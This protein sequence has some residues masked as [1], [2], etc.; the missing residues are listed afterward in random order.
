MQ[1]FRQ[2][3]NP[4]PDFK[5]SANDCFNLFWCRRR[6]SHEILFLWES[7]EGAWWIFSRLSD[8]R[9]RFLG[10]LRWDTRKGVWL[11]PSSLKSFPILYLLLFFQ[12]SDYSHRRDRCS[13]WSIL[14]LT[15]IW[16]NIIAFGHHQ[17]QAIQNMQTYFPTIFISPE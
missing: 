5:I 14:D 7:I 6:F 9:Y 12:R 17:F 1:L 4:E 8:K 11:S 10:L 13:T 2:G 15:S 3:L 16:K